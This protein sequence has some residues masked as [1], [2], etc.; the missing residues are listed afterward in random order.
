MFPL[1]MHLFLLVWICVSLSVCEKERKIRREGEKEEGERERR[2]SVCVYK[3]CVGDHGVQ[4]SLSAP[5]GLE[6]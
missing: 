3:D 2:K 1:K 5:L 6:L 4:K